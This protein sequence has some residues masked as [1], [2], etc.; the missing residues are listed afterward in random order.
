M[1]PSRPGTEVPA[2]IIVRSASR[3]LFRPKPTHHAT[4]G[5]VGR[6]ASGSLLL[7]GAPSRSQPCITAGQAMPKTHV[8]VPFDDVW[9]GNSASS[10]PPKRRVV[11]I[12]A[13]LPI[14]S[15][16]EHGRQECMNWRHATLGLPSLCAAALLAGNAAAISPHKPACDALALRAFSS[17]S[18]RPVEIDQYV[19][20]SVCKTPRPSLSE[21][22]A[23]GINPDGLIASTRLADLWSPDV[24]TKAAAEAAICSSPVALPAVD[25]T[26]LGLQNLGGQALDDLHACMVVSYV[27]GSTACVTRYPSAVAVE[28]VAHVLPGVGPSPPNITAVTT[29]NLSGATSAPIS[30]SA[31]R[32]V[33]I[34]LG[35]RMKGVPFTADLGFDAA[36]KCSVRGPLPPHLLQ[37]AMTA[38][39]ESVKCGPAHI[40]DLSDSDGCD[41]DSR[42]VKFCIDPKK[43]RLVPGGVP[44]SSRYTSNCPDGAS[45]ITGHRRL[46]A[47]DPDVDKCFITDYHLQ[48]CGI[49][50]ICFGDEDHCIGWCNGSSWLGETVVAPTLFLSGHKAGQTQTS[51]LLANSLP[52]GGIAY[53]TQAMPDDF[54]LKSVTWSVGVFLGGTPSPS[55]PDFTL[56]AAAPTHSDAHL[57]FCYAALF[58]QFRGGLVVVALNDPQACDEALNKDRVK[59]ILT[60]GDP[61]SD[62]G[63]DGLVRTADPTKCNQ[64]CSRRH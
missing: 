32:T 41:S 55:G 7:P 61:C 30:G 4:L 20:A 21:I 3:F 14:V 10:G 15:T 19:R 44:S 64:P 54:V 43:E 38:E 28:A 2:L 50:K 34:P 23:I 18:S 35:D 40:W 13:T 31:T 63:D 39:G 46:P 9:V 1:L 47:S 45:H 58:D 26:T 27:S 25:L 57:G 52:W 22:S 33:V 51:T 62:R 37:I 60:W 24:K 8:L 49:T 53:F 17:S 36:P 59:E 5:F 42:S 11:L 12:P 16:N 6:A 48:S 56:N 29:S